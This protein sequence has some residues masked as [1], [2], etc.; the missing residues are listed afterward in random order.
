[1]NWLQA[2]ANA[3]ADRQDRQTPDPLT[4]EK[5]FLEGEREVNTS[6]GDSLAPCLSCL[7]S[8]PAPLV[9]LYVAWRDGAR[10]RQA[11][12]TE[13]PSRLDLYLEDPSGPWI[14][15]HGVLIAV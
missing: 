13:W 2:V 1:M 8:T 9:P 10:Y 15:K 3:A 14:R 6:R 4:R 12:A 7:S 11:Q 5:C